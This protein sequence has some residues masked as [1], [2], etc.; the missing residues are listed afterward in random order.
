[1]RDVGRAVEQLVDAVAAVRADD[2]AVLFLGDLFD[3]VAK[4]ADQDTRL[5][6]LD[7][8]VQAL[9]RGLDNAD[10]VRIGLGT[11]ADVVRLVEIGMVPLVVE[12]DVNVENISVQQDALVGD[13]VA[14]DFVDRRA[15]RLGEVVIVEGR[16]I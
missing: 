14:D 4:L 2:A 1:M 16:R 7:R 8:L 15:T 5:D 3:N 11:V 6:R 9:A 12:C 13:A 10:I